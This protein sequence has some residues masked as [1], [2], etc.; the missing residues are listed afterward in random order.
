MPEGCLGHRRPEDVV[1]IK[2]VWK[3][4]YPQVIGQQV[5]IL[6]ESGDTA[7]FFVELGKN[8]RILSV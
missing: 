2:Q 4:I 3:Y 5:G 1:P 6:H 7:D 8:T